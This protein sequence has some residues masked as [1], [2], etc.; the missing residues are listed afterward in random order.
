M[1]GQVNHDS[2]KK[3]NRTSPRLLPAGVRCLFWVGVALF[4][5]LLGYNSLN[6][7]GKF[8]PDSMFYMDGAQNLLAGRGLSSSMA[9]LDRLLSTGQHL[10]RPMTVWAPVYPLLVAAGAGLGWSVPAAALAVP[11]LFFLLTLVAAYF[12]LAALYDKGTAL[13]CAG[14]LLHF[15]PLRHVSTHAWSETVGLAPLLAALFLLVHLK[16]Q[17]GM[18]GGKGAE[19]GN[20]WRLFAAGSLAGLAVG[21]RYALMPLFVVGLLLAVD[22]TSRRASLVRA[23]SFALGFA[24]FMVPVLGRN[25]YHT[26]RLGGP[27]W[28]DAERGVAEGVSQTYHA[29]AETAWAPGFLPGVILTLLFA[30][31]VLMCCLHAVGR[32][33]PR[34]L[35]EAITG[36]SQSV[37][38]LWTLAYAGFLVF[39]QTRA[40]ID[41]ID[42]RLILPAALTLYLLMVALLARLSRIPQA[43]LGGIAFVLLAAAIQAEA[44]TARTLMGVS[45]TPVWDFKAKLERSET[46]EWLSRNVSPGDLIVAEDGLDLPV[47]LGPI[48][49]AFFSKAL[50]PGFRLTYE[51]VMAFHER[52]NGCSEPRRAYLVLKPKP[53][54]RE[55]IA[56]K[57]G[58]LVADLVEGRTSAYPGLALNRRFEDGLI[59]DITCP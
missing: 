57:F 11:I 55:G 34:T 45:I 9:Q 52:E 19:G 1:S 53:Q 43:V 41:P 50:S 44:S 23:G 13:L 35:R 12:L 26:G 2:R 27:R 30:A 18:E 14:F 31:T 7:E 54:D 46:L 32:K 33:L 39:S 36:K 51:D 4:T 24:L 59:F 3:G 40:R 29:F 17:K 37:L 49:T 58:T 42:A 10:P 21:A 56:E 25:L 47:Y 28:G 48:D 16:D 22:R 15:E 5:G 38:L 20:A 8:S 6:L